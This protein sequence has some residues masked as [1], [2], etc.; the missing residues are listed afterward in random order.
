MV[1]LVKLTEIPNNKYLIGKIF[2][3]LAQKR[4]DYRNEM[5]VLTNYR[6]KVKLAQ[7]KDSSNVQQQYESAVTAL[8]LDSMRLSVYRVQIS[9]KYANHNGKVRS[10]RQ[11]Y[12]GKCSSSTSIQ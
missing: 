7:G 6:K 9:I 1:T 11:L 8:F 5:I 3:T 2:D 10:P 12:R 4:E